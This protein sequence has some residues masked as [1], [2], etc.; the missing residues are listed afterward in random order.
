M[1]YWNWFRS[2]FSVAAYVTKLH[3]ERCSLVRVEGPRSYLFLLCA[4]LH[5]RLAGDMDGT[6][7]RRWLVHLKLGLLG[8][9]GSLR[10][11]EPRGP[12]KHLDTA[13]P[14]I[15]GRIS[16]IFRPPEAED[17]SIHHPDPVQ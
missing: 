17:T 9:E 1:D 7:K 16:K 2:Q 3:S 10:K 12:Y 11:K 5:G 14:G 4:E 8:D 15:P 13:S 6:L